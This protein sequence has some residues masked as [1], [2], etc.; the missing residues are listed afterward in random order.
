MSKTSKKQRAPVPADTE[1]RKLVDRLVKAGLSYEEI[2]F[3]LRVSLNSIIRWR[4]G[5]TPQP[6]HM[7][8]LRDLVAKRAKK[9]S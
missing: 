8:N 7:A 4:R 3:N 1:A 6:G 9:A 2:A 5:V